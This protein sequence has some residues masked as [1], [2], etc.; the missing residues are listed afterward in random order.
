MAN[1][2]S[3]FSSGRIGNL[4]LKNRLVMPPMVRNYADAKGLVTKKYIDH[5]SSIAKGGV[6]MMILEA[7]FIRPEGKGFVN[8]LGIHSDTVIPGLKKLALA[9]HKHGAKIGIQLYHAGRQ[10]S[11]KNS[12]HQPVAPS[13][14]P[15]PTVNEI[16]HELTVDEIHRLVRAYGAAALRAKKAGLDFVEIHGAHGYLITQFLSPFSNRREDEYGGTPEKRMRFLREVFE[17]VRKDV[18]PHF[19]ITVRLSGEEMVP[20]GLT[21]KDT[22]RIAKELEEM[23]ADA[24][25][26]SVGNYASYAR[27]YMIP[28]MAIED[29]PL[30]HLASGVKKA[31]TIP[32]I[33]VGKLRT[34]EIV[35]K[36]LKDGLADFVAIGRTLLAD[37]EWP[38]KVQQ[39]RLKEINKCIA[40]NQGCIERL[41]EQKDV[42][43][44]VNPK[45]SREGLFAKKPS[46]QKNVL[47]IGGGPA[48]LSAA[49]TAAER[50]HRVTLYEKHG[51]LGGQV[52]AAAAL[53]HRGDWGD[54][55][56]TLV[57]DVQRLGV[58]IHLNTEFSPEMTSTGA[59][60]AAIIAMGSSPTRP[61]IPGI[62]R[63]NVV[64]ARDL[65]EGWSEAT[66]KVV[67][68][69]GGCMGAQVAE[70]LANNG[71]SVT[72]VEA[73][74]SIATEAPSD[75]RALLL[76]RLRKLGVKTLTE[77]KVMNIGPK[78]VSVEGADGAKNLSADTV[79][80][81]F[82]AFSNDGI[83]AELKKLVK[84]VSVVGDAKQPRRVTEAVAEGA[85]AA[86]EIS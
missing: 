68:A 7:S 49:K 43:C 65:V 82:G 83:T 56:R 75:D 42:W 8:E 11:S 3:I 55:L 24:L 48:G 39:G 60:D 15:D 57:Q 84:N 34:P 29:G 69:G 37:P 51:K 23:G 80:V 71:H 38:N 31:V 32:V 53:P 45:T 6:G 22:I 40:C 5:I 77:T 72:I 74:G 73:T 70:A 14:I 33:A 20:G 81:C 85:L 25:H 62:G 36:T 79:V 12:G 47:I 2:S 26:I 19:P 64:I 59:Y 63:T 17:A 13:P 86:L 30:L 4:T 44:T 78:S 46:R 28:P 9:A 27:G 67:I 35:E 16:P 76:E 21:L 10:T 58:T 50:G 52:I 54:F 1:F 66:G 61:N 18:G 41:F